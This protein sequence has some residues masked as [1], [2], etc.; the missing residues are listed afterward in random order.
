MG[1]KLPKMGTNTSSISGTSLADAIFSSTQQR[2]LGLLFGQPDRSFFTKELIDLA[3]AGSGTVQRDLARLQDSGLVTQAL[4]GTQKHY[5]ANPRS[6]IY[7]ELVAIVRKT[8]GPIGVLRSALAPLANDILFALLYGS[9]AKGEARAHSDIDVLVVSDTLTLEPLFAALAPAET[10]LGRTISPT[11]YTASEFRRR[12][13]QRS[14]F[15]TKVLG[16]DHVELLG[17][18]DDVIGAG[19]P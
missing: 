9:V 4:V 13:A 12:V 1:K 14:P 11:L 7:E 15:I 18:L 8:S 6:P 10:A 16:G 19:E 5:R 3:G 17:V 2:V